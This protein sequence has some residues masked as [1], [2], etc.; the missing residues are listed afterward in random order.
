[1]NISNKIKTGVFFAV[2]C[3][4]GT[5]N[6][7]AQDN[8]GFRVGAGFGIASG[9]LS[10]AP[11]IDGYMKFNSGLSIEAESGLF[12][13]G[14]TENTNA[15]LTVAP[16]YSIKKDMFITTIGLPIGI[17]GTRFATGISGNFDFIIANHFTVGLDINTL[18]VTGSGAYNLSS[19]GIVFGAIF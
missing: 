16:G 6:A 13:N 17:T 7:K 8:I 19:A 1:L 15:V 9:E 18:I 14:S 5:H 2:F 4:L 12:F 10:F 3:I 11:V